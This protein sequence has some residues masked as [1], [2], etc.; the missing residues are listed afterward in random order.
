MELLITH[1]A[2]LF[3]GLPVQQEPLLDS[4]ARGRALSDVSGH[5]SD[6]ECDFDACIWVECFEPFMT[7][8]PSGSISALPHHVWTGSIS[9][10]TRTEK[11]PDLEMR[12]V[13]IRGC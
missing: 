7:D 2:V 12:Q 5:L 10:E 11:Q 6:E 1:H 4:R 9:Y 8:F 13:W 3:E